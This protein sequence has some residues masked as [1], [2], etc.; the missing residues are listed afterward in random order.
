MKVSIL[1][2]FMLLLVETSYAQYNY[3]LNITTPELEGKKIK[4]YIL[5]NFGR[6]AL[7]VDSAIFKNGMV[8][9]KGTMSQP[10]HF[11]DLSY[12]NKG[13]SESL[14]IPLDSGEH[15]V[16]LK[17]GRGVNEP[18]L[19]SGLETNSMKIRAA[20]DQQWHTFYDKYPLKR[21]GRT[22]PKEIFLEWLET[23]LQLV[24]T[25]PNDFYSLLLLHQVAAS[26][27]SLR[28]AKSV[29]ETW[30]KLD[31]KVTESPLGIYVY[32]RQKNFTKGYLAAQVGKDIINF[33]VSDIDGDTFDSQSLTGQN[34]LIVLSATWC[35]PCQKQLPLLK[36]LYEKYK[37]SG[38]KVVY[39]NND[40]DVMRWKSHVEKN[41]LT[42][43]NVSE[44]LK[45]SD[46]KI[47]KSF[48]VY[49]VPTCILVDAKGKITYNSDQE[50][51]GLDKLELAIKQTI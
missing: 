1:M 10:V 4:L 47:S 36:G 11:V 22:M 50:D 3:I 18:P 7:K 32:N 9:L 46:S 33:T 41:K 42:W 43:I 28:H 24:S 30:A 39:F 35:L 37:T 31:T 14:R 29:L 25:H 38:L 13:K 21:D 5:D 8:R 12:K 34:Y 44:K 51:T 15:S 20:S 27:V 45:F 2:I 48:G 6:E 40:D 19:L 49:A 17:M 26:E 23:E 16:R